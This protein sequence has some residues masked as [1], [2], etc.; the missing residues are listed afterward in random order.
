MSVVDN[1]H[2]PQQYGTHPLREECTV[3]I[4]MYVLAGYEST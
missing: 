1:S 4:Y 2:E 3:N